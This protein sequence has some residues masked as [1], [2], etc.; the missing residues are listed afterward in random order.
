M[1][2]RDCR[3]LIAGIGNIFL[4]D[5]AFGV[6]VAQR[7]ATHALPEG[8]HVVDFGIRGLD[9]T[10]TLLDDH[11]DA[12]VLVDAAQRGGAPGT[13]YVIEPSEGDAVEPVPLDPSEALIDTHNMDPAKVLRL[14]RA[15]GGH[16]QH[17]L[18]L[19]CEPQPC[20]SYEEMANGLRRR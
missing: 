5:D 4:G 17:I 2:D 9:L 13:L 8:V 1:S 10:Y 19:G 7:L 16:L 18:L 14:V 3:V 11:Y 6:E 15:L 20:D 12:V